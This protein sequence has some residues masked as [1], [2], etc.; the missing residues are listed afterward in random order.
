MKRKISDANRLLIFQ[1]HVIPN[2]VSIHV[3]I[4]LNKCTHACVRR[5]A[6]LHMYIHYMHAHIQTC[7]HISKL[8]NQQKQQTNQPSNQPTNK[9][10]NQQTNKPTYLPTYTYLYLPI[11]AYIHTCMHAYVHSITLLC[12]VLHCI[13]LPCITVHLITFDYIWFTLHTCIHTCMH[14]C[15]HN[16]A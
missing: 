8:T 11:P 9:P 3:L 12:I 5:R 16:H 14:A 6:S 2:Y 13:K 15:I 7:E 1:E 4:S 10:S